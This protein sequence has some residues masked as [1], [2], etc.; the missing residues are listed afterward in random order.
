MEYI[1]LS[2][3]LEEDTPVHIGLKKPSTSQNNTIYNN[4][5]NTYLICAENHSGTHVDAPA[6]FIEGGKN[7][8]EYGPED[9]V[10][11]N[12][13]ILD[14]LAD[15]KK[16][17][18]LDDLLWAADNRKKNLKELME[19]TDFLILNTGFHTYRHNNIEKYLRENPG[20]K[21]DLIKY[22]RQYYPSIRAIGIDSI[23]IS[24]FDDPKNAI[25][26]HQM[27]FVADDNYGEPLLLVEDMDLNKLSSSKIIKK[28][29]VIPWQV[30]NVDSAPCTVIAY[31]D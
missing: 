1:Y 9:L 14:I 4:G 2:Y 29:M 31:L 28:L 12:I 30:K 3:A 10:F 13:L 27:A 8:S 18:A 20:I 6:H 19:K 24:T 23:S 11:N 22:L 15:S 5:Y 21:P 25:L 17:I 16:Q 26:T 7:I